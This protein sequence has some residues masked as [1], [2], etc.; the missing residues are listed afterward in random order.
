MAAFVL[1]FATVLA[2]VL[3]VLV[4][5]YYLLRVPYD[6]LV[7]VVSGRSPETLRF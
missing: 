1:G 3:V 2:A 6:D 7:G 4:V 5:G